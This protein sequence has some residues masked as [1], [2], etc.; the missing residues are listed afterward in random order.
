MEISRIHAFSA[1][2]RPA[3]V[4]KQAHRGFE[5]PVFFHWLLAAAQQS[6]TLGHAD[7]EDEKLLGPCVGIAKFDRGPIGISRQ[8]PIDLGKAA[9]AVV[10]DEELRKI[11]EPR[12][13][14][15]RGP[16]GPSRHS[17]AF[18]LTNLLQN[19]FHLRRGDGAQSLSTEIALLEDV[20]R[21][22]G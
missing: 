10:L 20:Q 12:S 16:T 7:N 14:G 19:F 9:M 2:T 22:R 4:Q 15:Y 18:Q 5:S 6:Q 3:S 8:H 17:S 21:E 1:S 13:L 11:R